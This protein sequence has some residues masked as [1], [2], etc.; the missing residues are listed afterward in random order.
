LPPITQSGAAIAIAVDLYEEPETNMVFFD[1]A[2][3]GLRN[4]MRAVTHLNVDAAGIDKTLETV[5]D[6]AAGRD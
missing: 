4:L 6:V 5:P 3:Y 2:R 1:G